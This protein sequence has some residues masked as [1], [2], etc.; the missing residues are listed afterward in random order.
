MSRESLF[1]ET[2]LIETSQKFQQCVGGSLRLL[3]QNPVSSIFEHDLR[4]MSHIQG[5][6]ASNEAKARVSSSIT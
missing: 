1:V 2:A 4:M 5:F 6:L 3:L